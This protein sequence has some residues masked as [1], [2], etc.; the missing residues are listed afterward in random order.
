MPIFWPESI[1][2]NILKQLNLSLK[3]E[4]QERIPTM[5]TTKAHLYFA[6]ERLFYLLHIH[7]TF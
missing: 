5:A 4:S 7:T 3:L 6:C 1:L 2:E